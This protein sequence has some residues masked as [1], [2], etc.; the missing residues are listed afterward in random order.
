MSSHDFTAIEADLPLHGCD[1]IEPREDNVVRSC[2]QEERNDLF[3]THLSNC[4]VK[5]IRSKAG[6]DMK[7]L[8]DFMISCRVK[9][10]S[11]VQLLFL[12]VWF[13]SSTSAG[14]CSVGSV[15]SGARWVGAGGGWRG[16]GGG[17]GEE[18][19][20]EDKLDSRS[21]LAVLSG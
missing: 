14:H 2:L 11:T 13:S 21:L 16:G 8:E 20:K 4:K 18:D 1:S 7:T 17:E 9:Y 15:C 12:H 10:C 3:H 6:Y 5:S 19:K